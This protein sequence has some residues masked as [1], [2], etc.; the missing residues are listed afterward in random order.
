[1]KGILQPIILVV[2]VAIWLPLQAQQN[3]RWQQQVNYTLDVT[4][5]DTLHQLTGLAQ[6]DYHNNSNDTLRYI[7]FHIWPNAYKNDKTA[8][9]NQTI[10]NGNTALYFA[11]ENERGSITG[12]SF[13]VNN[14]PTGYEPH[15]THIDIIKLILP[16]PILPHS[17]AIITTPFKVQLPNYFSRGGHIGQHYQITQ[18]YPKPAVYDAN[19]WHPMPY[20]DQGEFYS[21][22][23]NFKVAITLPNNYTVAASGN[24]RNA[25]LLDQLKTIGKQPAAKQPAMDTHRALLKKQKIK[26]AVNPYQLV[27]KSSQQQQTWEYELSNAHDFAWFASKS[28]IVNYDTLQLA[29]KTIDVFTYY[30]PWELSQWQLSTKYAK[31]ATRF[32]SEHIGHYPYLTVN[33]VSGPQNGSSGGMEYPTITLITIGE[34]GQALDQVIA[35]EIGHNW[36]YGML[37]NNE[38]NYAWLDESVNSYYE[39][40]YMD[41]YYPTTT[42]TKFDAKFASTHIENALLQG[43]M[44]TQRDVPIATPA[45]Q[46]SSLQYGLITYN[47]GAQWLTSVA[48]T[49]GTHKFDSAIQ[50]LFKSNCFQHLQPQDFFNALQSYFPNTSDTTWRNG[51]YVSGN[52]SSYQKLRATLFANFNQAATTQYINITP[53]AGYNFY[54]GVLAGMAIHNYQLT[55][56]RFQFHVMPMLGTKSA[57]LSG[58]G[59]VSYHWYRKRYWLETSLSAFRFTTDNFKRPEDDVT[60]HQRTTRITPGIKITFYPSDARNT[61]RWWLQAK[62]F[63]LQEEVLNFS[64][65]VAQLQRVQRSINRLAAGVY[66]KSALYPYSADMVIDQ[67]DG[68]VRAA[69]TGKYFFNYNSSKQGVHTRFFAGAFLYT[70]QKTL[71]QQFATQRYH[72]NMTGPRGEE[73]YTYSGYF[74]GRNEFEGWQSQQ[75]IERDGF[76]KVGTELFSNRAGQS[77]SWLMAL[78]AGFDIP[79]AYNPL[80]VL[81]IKIPLRIFVDVGTYGEAWKD[82]NAGTGRFLYD[83]GIQVPLFGGI[84]NVYIPIVYSKV[85]RDYYKSV[86]G[87]QQFAKSI[88]FDIDL[89]KLQLHKNSQFSFL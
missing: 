58:S 51:I 23:G 57:A 69:L 20:L 33:V 79:N 67:G 44:R 30:H 80:Q 32:Y 27:P 28:F 72:L 46:Q 71:L 15:P 24:L 6:Y 75:M 76:F 49:M 37:A 19:G 74:V 87:N 81:P 12:L 83:A 14:Q 55:M 61:T 63:N 39:K 85:F 68:F 18:W 7:W 42:T 26:S 66:N 22:F 34:G 59:R 64:S 50:N 8:L 1:M 60:L 2:L 21:E 48:N 25:T 3:K 9:V 10:E 11:K 43:M 16:Q 5:D 29:N 84:A 53:V 47:K 36:W 86:F 77:D 13:S 45:A 62:H 4:L 65:G 73:D 17:S 88:S 40:R 52:A 41:R 31:Q 35:H 82:G 54:D 89:S 56:P 70:Q 38:R 78:N